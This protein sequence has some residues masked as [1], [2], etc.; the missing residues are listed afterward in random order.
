MIMN[1]LRKNN[2]HFNHL[3]YNQLLHIKSWNEVC[4]WPQPAAMLA[5]VRRTQG[6]TQFLKY[7]LHFIT[8]LFTVNKTLM[9]VGKISIWFLL[10][11]YNLYFANV[12]SCES[13]LFFSMLGN[14]L[15]SLG[16]LVKWQGIWFS[17]C[18]MTGLHWLD[19]VPSLLYTEQ[20]HSLLCYIN[21]GTNNPP[22][23]NKWSLYNHK[24]IKYDDSL[25]HKNAEFKS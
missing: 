19:L 2:D 5:L 14:Y 24:Q 3:Q 8:K 20:K 21:K 7:N 6:L 15:S 9:V 1:T 25:V 16:L 12:L 4:K 18:P 23:H 11:V 13:N 22:R 17:K 10:V